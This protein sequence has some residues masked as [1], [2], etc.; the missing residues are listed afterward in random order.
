MSYQSEMKK[1]FGAPIKDPLGALSGIVNSM[2][3][4]ITPIAAKKIGISESAL[5]KRITSIQILKI[6]DVNGFTSSS[7]NWKSFNIG[8]NLGLMLFFNSM[9]KLFHSR[10]AI[11][12]DDGTMSQPKI[13]IDESVK[14]A[15]NLMNAYW[16]GTIYQEKGFDAI[17]LDDNQLMQAGIILSNAE[18]FVLAHEFGHIVL[19]TAQKDKNITNMYNHFVTSTEN[20]LNDS[21]LSP[22]DVRT[23]APMWG[24]ELTCDWL[25]INLSFER[26]DPGLERMYAYTGT[27]FVFIA[28]N[29]LTMFLS[30]TNHPEFVN[31]SHPPSY[32]RL[33]ALRATIGEHNPPQILQLGKGMEDFS[34]DLLKRMQL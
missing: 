31:T 18:H 14:M 13:T 30:K 5:Q 22:K 27:E 21:G 19:H 12:H 9:A 4:K 28:Q 25:G 8:V 2:A 34:N 33:N 15:K 16:N 24:E 20:M 29:M 26:F 17:Q 10:M 11:L 1:R 3:A 7:D 23:M 6:Q 32:I